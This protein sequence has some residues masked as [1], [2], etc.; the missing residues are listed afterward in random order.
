MQS[1]FLGIKIL[2]DALVSSRIYPKF[3]D[4]YLSHV[5]PRSNAILDCRRIVKYCNGLFFFI[6]YIIVIKR[7]CVYLQQVDH[8]SQ[9]LIEIEHAAKKNATILFFVID[10]Q[11]RNVVTDIETANF[12]GNYSNLVLVIHPQDVVSG[13]KVAGE[14][15]SSK[16]ADD[17]KEALTVLHKITSHQGVLVFDNIPQALSKIVQVKLI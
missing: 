6:T 15:I 1:N 13:S 5:S 2:E 3:D 11:T 17:I 14:Q 7:T 4:L 10:S 16:E 9:D 12:A 8:W